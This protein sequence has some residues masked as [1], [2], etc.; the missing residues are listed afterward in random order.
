M[1]MNNLSMRE[2]AL[3]ERHAVTDQGATQ[4]TDVAA[5]EAETARTDLRAAL[6]AV[7]GVDAEPTSNEIEI[8]GIRFTA[9]G[10]SLCVLAPNGNEYQVS[11]WQ[12]LGSVIEELGM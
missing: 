2:R 12:Q 9:H 10:K 11:G 4:K 7:L 5:Q 8:E 1:A 6:K 3:Q